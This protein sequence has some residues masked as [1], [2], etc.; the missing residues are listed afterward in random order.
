MVRK[1]F[2]QGLRRVSLGGLLIVSG[3]VLAVPAT[4][5]APAATQIPAAD[6]GSTARS[7][8]YRIGARDRLTIRVQELPDL[9][10]EHVVGDDGTVN[11]GVVGSI[12]VRGLTESELEAR[13][14]ERLLQEGM[15]RATVT[16]TVAEFRS[17]PVSV[18]G[19]VARPGNQ[20]VP[21]RS[22]LIDLI[23]D[24]GGLSDQAG[25]KI[26][27]RRRSDNGLSDRVEVSTDDL[28]V[29]GDPKVNLPIYA[30]DMIHVLAMQEVAV[31]FLG[32]VNTV[33]TLTF[34]DN[35]KVTLLT[36]IARAGGLTETASNK[37]VIKREGEDGKRYEIPVDYRKLLNGRIAD[38]ELQDGD[39]IVVKESFF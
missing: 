6:R 2:I 9:T 18:L 23:L 27:V 1:P 10:G 26:I 4:A 38:V 15:R 29:L 8:G 11:L 5:Q 3:S 21:G 35:R 13:I 14:R 39:L 12:D 31:H 36:A 28:F 17:K 34:T 32:Q 33:G 16:A 19:A 7:A 37:L 20:V 30:G 22:T 24:A 25:K